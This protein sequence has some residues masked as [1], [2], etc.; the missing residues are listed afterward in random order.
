MIDKLKY[1]ARISGMAAATFAKLYVLIFVTTGITLIA[2]ILHLAFGNDSNPTAGHTD[3][4]TGLLGLFIAFPVQILCI[5]LII[6]CTF[7]LLAGVYKYVVKKVINRIINDNCESTIVPLLEKAFDKLRTKQ[8]QALKNGTDAAYGKLQLI[9]NIKESSENKWVKRALAYGIKKIK[10]D[11]VNLN[12][13]GMD[14]YEIIR[15]KTVTALRNVAKPDKKLI[16]LLI[17]LQF[18]LML[19]V[20]FIT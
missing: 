8:P 12:A 1:T 10:L 20:V 9:N 4:K 3:G 6:V 14:T 16:W 2:S 5:A 11:D 7:I 19:V 18:I 17:A 15:Q 13:E